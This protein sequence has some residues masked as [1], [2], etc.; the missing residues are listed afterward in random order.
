MNVKIRTV[1][2]R[3][4]LKTF[5][6]LPEKIHR[7][8]DKWVHPIYADEWVYFNPKKNTSFAFSDAVLFLAIKENKPVGRIMGIINR[9]YNEL[10]NQ[11][12]ARFSYLESYEDKEVVF[13]LL[14]AVETW[15]RQKGMTRVIGPYGFTDQDP[16]GFMIE[17]FEHGVTIASFYNME[18]MPSMVEE[19][20]YRKDID[21]FVYKLD[22]PET[23]PEFY[24]KIY[25]RAMR[26][27][28]YEIIELRKR[29]EIK[30]W[31][32]PVLRLMNLC[33]I[34]SEIYGY[35]PLTEKQMEELAASYLPVLDPRFIKAVKKDDEVI[36][37]IIGMPDMT[38][39]IRRARGRLFPFGFLKIIRA[40]KKT[41]QLDLLLGAIKPEYRG[42]GRD[43]LKG[44]KMIQSAQEAGFTTMDT[45]HEM[46]SNVRVRGEM[47]RMGGK[48]YKKYR[49]Y[50][51]DI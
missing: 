30:P 9:N 14:Q 3:L 51:K 29:K 36:A 44:V 6:Y 43:V 4:D 7:G 34:E 19:Y 46:E 12:T 27:G 39:G 2:S 21:W 40:A 25:E 22:V 45:H 49:A 17:G 18:W 5:I 33:Y 13:A 41:K 42:R 35:S 16:E 23:M 1:E 8:R 20:G 24:L 28:N 31:I 38:E 48:I 26:K 37:F 47:E 11:K 32:K 50:Q 15:A 10:R